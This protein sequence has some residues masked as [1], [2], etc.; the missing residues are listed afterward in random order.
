LA[1]ATS[2]RFATSVASNANG[3]KI[4]VGAINDEKTG[5]NGE[6]LAY[7]FSSGS[8]GWSEEHILSGSL[9]TTLLDNFGYSVNINSTG[10]YIVVGAPDDESPANAASSGLAYVFVSDSG[11]WSENR[12]YLERSLLVLTSVLVCLLS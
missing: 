7:V 11:G 1:S 10:E 12:F 9:A 3:N 5:T 8:S 2:D 6:G 4:V